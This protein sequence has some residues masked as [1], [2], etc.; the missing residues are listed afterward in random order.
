MCFADEDDD[1]DDDEDVVDEKETEQTGRDP[2]SN[3]LTASGA[4]K[5]LG[6]VDSG[7]DTVLQDDL[8]EY[9]DSEEVQLLK[10]RRLAQLIQ[11]SEHVVV[12]TGAGV[13]TAANLPDYRGPDGAW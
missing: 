5:G 7:K 12:H 4:N 13:S 9:V 8:T 2:K 3:P 10:A 6:D 11:R 1:A